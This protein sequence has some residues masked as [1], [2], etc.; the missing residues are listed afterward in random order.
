MR[1]PPLFAYILFVMKFHGSFKQECCRS[2][3]SFYIFYIDW[4][5]DCAVPYWT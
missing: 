2:V 4:M 1:V 5:V 3:N